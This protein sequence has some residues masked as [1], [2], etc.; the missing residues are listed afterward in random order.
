MLLSPV[1]NPLK[2][3][4]AEE[5]VRR[6]YEKMEG[7]S[8]QARI[9]MKIIRP[10]WQRSYTMKTWSKGEDFSMVLILSPA[11]DEGTAFLM[12][13][14]EIWNWLPG[15]NR[16]IKLPPSMMSQS[17]MGS[18][19]S[20]NDLVRESSII[21][22]YTYRMLGDTLLS[23]GEAYMIEMIPKPDAPIVW[24]KVIS[25]ITKENDLYI[26]AEYYDEDDI[27]IRLMTGKEIKEIGGRII[28]TVMEMIPVEEEGNMTVVI[29]EDIDFNID[30][31]ERFF[32]IQNLK[33]V[34]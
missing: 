27:L 4:S 31:S 6:S 14:N 20:N 3:Q 11:R 25:Y 24:S 30:I 26:R 16:T 15:V 19:F 2:A 32:S 28:P 9:T 17:W 8:S 34:D 10:D 1:F 29:Y 12:R 5:V 18:D 23:E 21:K 22:D 13:E 33:R 7:E